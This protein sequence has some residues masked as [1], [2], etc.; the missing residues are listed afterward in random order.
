MLNC[1]LHCAGWSI[2]GLCLVNI[3]LIEPQSKGKLQICIIAKLSDRHR[4]QTVKNSEFSYI[5]FLPENY[6]SNAE[7][8]K[9]WLVQQQPVKEV[10]K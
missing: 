7:Y 9:Q 4:S 8:K 2:V 10:H 1:A 5:I 6:T 3:C